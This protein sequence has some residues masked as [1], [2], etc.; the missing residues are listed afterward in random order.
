MGG[1][2]AANKTLQFLRSL[3][4]C[5]VPAT[6]WVLIGECYNHSI[7]LLIKSM[8]VDHNHEIVLA[9]TN[10]SMWSILH[11]C[12]IAILPGGVTAYEAAYAGLPTITMSFGSENVF[13][14]QELADSGVTIHTGVFSTSNL[15]QLNREVERLYHNRKAL[16]EMHCRCKKLIDGKGCLRIISILENEISFT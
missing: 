6:F 12:V 10:D 13:L 4:K 2:D 16:L 5:N 3:Q 11:N 1:G 15:V 9:K 8:D 7:D 14:I